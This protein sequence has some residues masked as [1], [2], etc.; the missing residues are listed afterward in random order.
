VAQD[1]SAAWVADKNAVAGIA[2]QKVA[3]VE[4]VGAE[5]FESHALGYLCHDHTA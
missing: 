3:E 4:N 2:E 1:S 5:T